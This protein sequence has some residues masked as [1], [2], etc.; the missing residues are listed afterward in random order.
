M[1]E[2][3]PLFP[4]LRIALR[5]ESAE[6]DMW[7]I[8]SKWKTSGTAFDRKPKQGITS[9]TCILSCAMLLPSFLPGGCHKLR[10]LMMIQNLLM[11]SCMSGLLMFENTPN[12][13]TVLFG[14]VS[15]ITHVT[16]GHLIGH[17]NQ[18]ESQL[19]QQLHWSA[20]NFHHQHRS[21]DFLLFGCFLKWWYPKMDGL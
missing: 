20:G 4:H 1:F 18:L 15:A 3:K 13:L 6:S 2:S 5:V 10:G 9:Y 7:T 19:M 16:H 17:W 11:N 14:T 12:E 8:T 21:E